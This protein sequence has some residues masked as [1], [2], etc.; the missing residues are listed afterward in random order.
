[1]TIVRKVHNLHG[2]VYQI[3]H[4]VSQSALEFRDSSDSTVHITRCPSSTLSLSDGITT[5]QTQ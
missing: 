1:M 4:N 3:I 5:Q 2:L